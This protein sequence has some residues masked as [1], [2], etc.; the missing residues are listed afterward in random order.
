MKYQQLIF[1]ALIFCLT[2]SVLPA[3]R[4]GK[5]VHHVYLGPHGFGSVVRFKAN[6]FSMSDGSSGFFRPTTRTQ[7]G[8]I[9]AKG[10]TF[11][12]IPQRIAFYSNDSHKAS[13]FQRNIYPRRRRI[14]PQEKCKCNSKAF[15]NAVAG[16]NQG[17]ATMC[18]TM[19]CYF[20][21]DSLVFVDGTNYKYHK[22]EN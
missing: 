21:N 7:I 11:L 8:S 20:K 1:L 18:D 9:V 14:Y 12:L 2:S 16:D 4:D 19:K 13:F 22:V 15:S 17:Y 3:R 5:Y 6:K 10:D